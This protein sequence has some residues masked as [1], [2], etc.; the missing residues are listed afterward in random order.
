MSVESRI[1]D[2]V[3][4]NSKQLSLI[5]KF[6]FGIFG[7]YMV[8]RLAEIN[9]RR[10]WAFCRQPQTDFPLHRAFFEMIPD[11]KRSL[12]SSVT[13]DDRELAEERAVKLAGEILL[14]AKE[15]GQLSIVRSLYDFLGH[16][17]IARR[18]VYNTYQA[19]N[20]LEEAE[21]KNLLGFPV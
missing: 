3:L 11:I 1:R 17:Q 4:E 2:A 9:G 8:D 6:H 18:A 21:L 10:L 16:S 7:Q 5:L 19:A 15:A 20:V 14:F 13:E 12:N